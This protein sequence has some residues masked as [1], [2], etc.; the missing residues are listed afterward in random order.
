MFYRLLEDVADLVQ[1]REVQAIDQDGQTS[2]HM[3]FRDGDA[4][5]TVARADWPAEQFTLAARDAARAKRLA[6]RVSLRTAAATHR[7]KD[8]RALTL[9]ELRD[10]V[11]VL[12]EERG[13]LDDDGRVAG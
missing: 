10:L 1:P 3:A 6:L 13:L 11:L 7:G 2:I 9:P 12:L 5:R 4:V 8:A